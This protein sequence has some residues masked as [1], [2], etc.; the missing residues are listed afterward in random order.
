MPKRPH[1]PYGPPRSPR[2][3]A[4]WSIGSNGLTQEGQ[5]ELMKQ[6]GHQLRVGYQ[7]TVEEPMPDHFKQLVKRL[8]ERRASSTDGEDRS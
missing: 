6:L 2:G 7:G 8:E 1:Q 4:G 3:H 5:A